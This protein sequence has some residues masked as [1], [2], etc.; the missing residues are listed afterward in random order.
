MILIEVGG[1][2]K[3]VEID[4]RNK[5]QMLYDYVA[6][7]CGTDDFYLT[8]KS[9]PLNTEYCMLDMGICKGDTIRVNIR[10]K[11]G[12]QHYRNPFNP[13]R[14]FNGNIAAFQNS[15]NDNPSILPTLLQHKN[16]AK[17]YPFEYTRVGFD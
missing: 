13:I 7:Q 14:E 2:T 9:K 10:L 5:A 11:G 1:K 6:S 16:M 12:A 3:Y 4:L 15:A 8:A 17:M